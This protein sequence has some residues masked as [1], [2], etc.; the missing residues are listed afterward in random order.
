MAETTRISPPSR[1][2]RHPRWFG[3]IL[4]AALTGIGVAQARLLY[5]S[6]AGP[7]PMTQTEVAE[8]RDPEEA[9]RQFIVIEGSARR[10][11]NVRQST[12]KLTGTEYPSTYWVLPMRE[13]TLLLR[14]YYDD[15]GEEVTGWVRPLR[16][17]PPEQFEQLCAEVPYL[18]R[19]CLPF[20]LDDFRRRPFGILLAVFLGCGL[21][22]AGWMIV[23][24]RV[25][26][27]GR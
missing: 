18:E 19:R 21:L 5:N 6:L 24:G 22:A 3:I 17:V 9:W 16:E 14:L 13:H 27:R 2:V 12:N 15:H 8:L 20:L 23:L 11:T 10:G 25:P 7:F 4:L 1:V 26:L